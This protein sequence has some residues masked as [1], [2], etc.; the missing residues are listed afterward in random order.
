MLGEGKKEVKT[1]KKVLLMLAFVMGLAFLVA[2]TNNEIPETSADMLLSVEMNPSFEFVLDDE[3]KVKTFRLKNEDA[4]ILAAGVDLIGLHYE[5][6][7][8]LMIQQ[9]I[10]TGYLDVEVNDQAIALMAANGKTDEE[11]QF[12]EAVKVQLQ[13]YLQEQAIGAVVLNHGE[14]DD[15]LITFSEEHDVSLGLAKLMMSYIELYPDALLDD[16]IA[17]TPKELTDALTT[18]HQTWMNTYQSEREDNMIQLKNELK[19]M[20]QEKV[21]AHRAAVTAGTKT[22]PDMTGVEAAYKNDYEGM[23]EDYIERNAQRKN[24]AKAKLSL[25]VPYM[26][27][28]DINPAVELIVDINGYVYSV[29]YKNEDAEIVGA[30]LDLIGKT[31]QEA[32][33]L[34]MNAAV[35]TGYIDVERSDNGVALMAGSLDGDLDETFR[36]QVQTMLQTYF[37]E[38]ALGAVVFNKAEVNDDIQMLVDT[39]GVSYGY[40]KLVLSYLEAYPEETVEDALLLTSTELIEALAAFQLN[41]FAQYRLEKEPEALMIKNQ[42]KEAVQEKVQ[43]H[44]DA[45]DAG[46]RTQP[47][48]TGVAEAWVNHYETKVQEYVTRNEERKDAAKDKVQQG[49]GLVLSVDINPQAEFVVDPEGYVIS[50]MFKNEDAEIVGAGLLLLGQTYQQALQTYLNAAVQ[51]GY[52][53]VDRADNAVALQVSH[54][55]EGEESAFQNQVELQLNAYFQEHAL[56]VVMLKHG[57]IDEDVQALMDEY[58]LSAGQAKLILNYLALFPEKTL[59]EVL[60]MPIQELVIHIIDQH[61]SYMYTYQHEREQ[62]A[63]AI[64][65]EMAAA[66]MNQVHAHEQAVANG[67]KTQPDTTEARQAYLTDYEG[68]HAEY[69]TRNQIRKDAAKA[70]V[71]QGNPS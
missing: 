15:A 31:T 52:I 25:H 13:T 62:D 1:M 7:L 49:Q 32:L 41:A 48:L 5:D 6:A 37:Q 63:Q 64:K 55:N 18:K 34:Y 4:E 23:K 36:N 66:C 2:C 29:M 21:E 67:T 69:V 10:D 8:H 12:R 65:N 43:A 33:Q 24:Q 61:Q 16:V 68:L 57:E 27:S 56:G 45:V 46:T 3:E 47:D 54:M 58:D 11:N 14:V 19:S 38:N 30:G 20:V 35:D 39:Y 70:R 26:L 59:D 9:A 17:L 28:V 50:V 22:Q 60:M 51:T 44:R 71:N 40:A 53:D 42:M